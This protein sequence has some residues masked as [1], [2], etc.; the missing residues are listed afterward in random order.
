MSPD[1]LDDLDP[2]EVELLEAAASEVRAEPPAATLRERLFASVSAAHRWDD[3]V[4]E[5]AEAMKLPLDAA[6]RLLATV[7]EDDGWED[8]GLPGVRLLHFEG[9]PGTEDAITGFVRIEVGGTFPHHEHVGQE[10]VIVLQGTCVDSHGTTYQRGQRIDQAPGTAHAI[11]VTS[12][13]PLLYLAVV[14]V[15]L[16]M[17]GEFLGPDDPRA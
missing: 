15:G 10:T 12:D 16:R 1:F 6:E 4:A 9:G 5:L 11:T 2:A 8:S 3:F 7:D 13:I 17:D 14:Q